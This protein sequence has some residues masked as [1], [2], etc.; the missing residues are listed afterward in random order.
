M[1]QHPGLACQTQISCE[2]PRHV[3]EWSQVR[4]RLQGLV[5]SVADRA[6]TLYQKGLRCLDLAGS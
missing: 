1:T 4:V 2:S 6:L 5:G 3:N